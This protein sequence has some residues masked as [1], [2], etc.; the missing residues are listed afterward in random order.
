MVSSSSEIHDAAKLAV[1]CLFET[2]DILVRM[3]VETSCG[4]ALRGKC[5]GIE[6]AISA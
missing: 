4:I 6:K 3:C 5:S 1:N 2:S